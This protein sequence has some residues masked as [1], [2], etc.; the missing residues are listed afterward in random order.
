MQIKHKPFYF[1]HSQKVSVDRFA[2]QSADTVD[3]YKCFVNILGFLF[4]FWFC[5]GSESASSH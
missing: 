5:M 2:V 3:C 1:M 4:F